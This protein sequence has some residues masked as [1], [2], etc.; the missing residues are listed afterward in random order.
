MKV[1]NEKMIANRLTIIFFLIIV[2]ISIL[3][4]LLM[5]T[6]PNTAKMKILLSFFIF[7]LLVLLYR[8]RCF[9]FEDSGEVITIKEFHP[10][11][12]KNIIFPS[13][14]FP[15]NY[16]RKLSMEKMLI[17]YTMVIYFCAKN[18]K[19]STVKFR[20]IALSDTKKKRIQNSFEGLSF[21]NNLV[22]V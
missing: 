7:I 12:K 8:L 14:E 6:I 10:L 4:M 2:S 1:T 20:I 5:I 15:K 3:T 13:A 11:F 19:V 16:V 17:G 22:E 18:A 9:V 21:V